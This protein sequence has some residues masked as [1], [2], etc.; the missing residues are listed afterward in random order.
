MATHESYEMNAPCPCGKGTFEWTGESPTNGYSRYYETGRTLNCDTCRTVWEIA[1][2]R[3]ELCFKADLELSRA[4]NE[5]RGE[6][7]GAMR[8]NPGSAVHKQAFEAAEAEYYAASKV[9]RRHSYE[10]Y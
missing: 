10:G 1:K 6:A 2:G 7:R 3:R 8:E 9:I 4:A 5:R